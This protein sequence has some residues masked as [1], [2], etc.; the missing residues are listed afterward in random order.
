[1]TGLAYVRHWTGL[2]TAVI[3]AEAAATFALFWAAL[4]AGDRVWR[5]LRRRWY[6]PPV[7]TAARMQPRDIKPYDSPAWAAG[8]PQG[9]D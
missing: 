8:D 5:R 1:M 7:M 2:D 3:A 9:E 6:R 4:W